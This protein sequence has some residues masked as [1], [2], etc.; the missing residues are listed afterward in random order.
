M[1]CMRPTRI[2][3]FNDYFNNDHFQFC[4]NYEFEVL[5]CYYMIDG[6]YLLSFIF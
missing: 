3:I 6:T 4:S 1:I 5:L 2:L